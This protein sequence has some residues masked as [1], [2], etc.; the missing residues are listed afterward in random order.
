VQQFSTP[1]VAVAEVGTANLTHLQV[2]HL[3]VEEQVVVVQTALV[4]QTLVVAVGHPTPTQT[5]VDQVLW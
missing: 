3:V 2:Y 1:V 5:V 4:V